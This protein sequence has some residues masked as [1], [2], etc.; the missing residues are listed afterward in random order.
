MAAAAT[1]KHPSCRWEDELRNLSASAT[2]SA[3][4][5]SEAQAS[6]AVTCSTWGNTALRCATIL[7]AE[8]GELESSHRR[9]LPT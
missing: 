3:H 8:V 1:E 6:Q 4:V 9:P 2:I 7:R 5:S